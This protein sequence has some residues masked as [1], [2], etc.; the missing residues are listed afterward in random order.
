MDLI[1]PGQKESLAKAQD[2][3]QAQLQALPQNQKIAILIFVVAAIGGLYWWLSFTPMETQIATVREEIADLDQKI[4][5][6]EA[7]VRR[8]DELKKEYAEIETDLVR[9]QE[10]LPPE[11]EAALLLKQISQMSRPKG[12]DLI[13]WTPG[14]RV[15][16][17]TGTYVSLPVNI[18]MVG[19]YHAITTF[20]DQIKNLKRVLSVTGATLGSATLEKTTEGAVQVGVV[21]DDR[22]SRTEV[23]IRASFT[24]TAYAAPRGSSTEGDV[25]AP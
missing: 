13:S 7:K 17:E 3:I 18:Q 15:E 10:A 20:F 8:L 2:V 14:G 24:V 16:S 21:T 9:L 19:G 1:S 12:L 22:S 6:D 5:I 23:R 25:S 4:Q 11:E